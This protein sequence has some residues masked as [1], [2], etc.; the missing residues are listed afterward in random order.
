MVGSALR[1]NKNH[2]QMFLT[3]LHLGLPPYS[4]TRLY[5]VSASQL[6]RL[7]LSNPKRIQSRSKWIGWEDLYLSLVEHGNGRNLM[8]PIS[9]R[10]PGWNFWQIFAHRFW[11]GYWFDIMEVVENCVLS[12]KNSYFVLSW[13]KLTNH[14]TIWLAQISTTDP[15]TVDFHCLAFILRSF[16][17]NIHR[18]NFVNGMTRT[19]FIAGSL[20]WQGSTE[21]LAV[22]RR[23]S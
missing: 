3:Y 1:F 21:G 16:E 4:C 13:Q 18:S 14:S 23:L 5:F 10:M 12:R 11:V 8:L 15:N 6:D 17:N 20:N 22:F 19:D 2:S 9:V 7:S